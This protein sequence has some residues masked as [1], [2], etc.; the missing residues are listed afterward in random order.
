MARRKL[1]WTR[2][3]PAISSL[4]R[5]SSATGGVIETHDLLTAYRVQAGLLAGP[6]GITAMRIRM[7]IQYSIPV[8]LGSTAADILSL[9]MYYGIKVIDKAQSDAMDI[10]EVPAFGPQLSPHDDW[11]AW[12]TVPVKVPTYTAG[13]LESVSGWLEADVRSMRKVDE[14]G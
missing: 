6:V 8:S 14:L 5:I 10:T 12:G 2:Q 4:T 13:A 3:A 11:M 9:G 7:N 1:I